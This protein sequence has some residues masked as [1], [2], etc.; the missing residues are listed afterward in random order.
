M[1]RSKAKKT[2]TGSQLRA[3][4]KQKGIQIQAGSLAGLVEEA[5]AAY[6]DVDEVIEAVVGA[7]ITKKVA[8]L[9]PLVVVKG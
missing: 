2:F 5:P 9:R 4:L 6:K 7:G 8:R 1:S 3:E